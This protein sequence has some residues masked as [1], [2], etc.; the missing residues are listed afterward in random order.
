MIQYEKVIFELSK[1]GRVGYRLPQDDFTGLEAGDLF[2]EE[3]KRGNKAELPEV[4]ENQVVR[5]YTNLS[6]KNF[7]VDTGFY[8]LGSCTMKYNPKINDEI[9][10]MSGFTCIHPLQP[11]ESAQGAMALLYDLEEKIAEI[12]GMDAVSLQPAAGA[13][14]ELTGMMMVK[15]YHEA[16]NDS[17]RTKIIVP[18]AAHGT[19]PATA[20]MCGFEIVEVPSD[21]TGGVDVEALK[22]VLND[23]IAGLMLTNPSTLGLF[24]KNIEEIAALIHE[25][26][27]LLYY[28]GA[29][30]NAIMGKT[31]PGD[32]GFD[33]VHLNLH[34]TMSTPHGGGGPGAGPVG[35]KARIADFLPKPVIVKEEENY[36]FDYDRPLSIGKMKGFYGNFSVLVRAYTYILTMG[37]EGLK[38]A[39]EMAV[40]NANYMQARLK[41]DYVLPFDT[42]C[43]HEFVLDGLKGTSELDV[44]TLDVAKRLLDHGYHPPTI[45]FPLIVHNALMIE[46][47]ETESLETLEAFCDAMIEIAKEA[48]TSPELLKNAPT[49]TVIRRVDEVRAA[50][51]PVLRWSKEEN[52]G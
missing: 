41:E 46:P 40:L 11:E 5:H 23:E 8:P 30:L 34:K 51:K 42:I 2:P 50:R 43:K 32:M 27:G 16:R 22:A 4:S 25:A 19:N 44:T 1:E 29:N 26:G 36:R 6:N 39:S 35:V 10:G 12:T 28:D 18:D 15:A 38:A 31:R 13:H 21:Q 48:K 20:S 7:G 52:H 33:I 24:E 14:G 17:K 49:Q 9:A 47:T 45:Y 3:L 37:A